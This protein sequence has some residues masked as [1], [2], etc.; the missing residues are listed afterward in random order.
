MPRIWLFS[1]W[2]QRLTNVQQEKGNLGLSS[3]SVCGNVYVH[4]AVWHKGRGMFSEERGRQLVKS[5]CG[6]CNVQSVGKL[7]CVV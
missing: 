1:K 2:A 6:E 3:S 4:W 5:N 7:A